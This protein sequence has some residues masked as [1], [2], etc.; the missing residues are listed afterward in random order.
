MSIVATLSRNPVPLLLASAL[1]LASSPAFAR[2]VDLQV[3]D[4]HS[5][6]TIPQLAHR[7]ERW[8]AGEQ[9]RE[10]TVRLSNRSGERVLAVLSVDGVNAIS[11][12]S[13]DPSQTGY[14]LD[15]WQSIDV[16]GWRKSERQTAAFHF[17]L[18]E[19]SYAART[20]RPQNVGVIGVAVYRE[21][22][23][24]HQ[25]EQPWHD[26]AHEFAKREAAPGSLDRTP[27]PLGAAP[28]AP[29]A[30]SQ[31][32]AQ[33]GQDLGTGHGRREWSPA[34]HT[35]FVRA[36]RAP[37]QITEVR[38]DSRESLIAQG[39]LPRHHGRLAQG[40]RAFGNGFVA[41]PPRW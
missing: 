17:T 35:E 7:G 41:D 28:A 12:E 2:I 10:F 23:L 37:E 9:G 27:E 5:G 38:Y 39:I 8:V 26:E 11:G 33:R 15:P 1:A 40:P 31:E 25:Y 4:R 20:G 21:A 18:G 13:A 30:K 3:I 34:R 36:T 6:R 24:V 29:S 32:F 14:V 19:R 22:R 16:R